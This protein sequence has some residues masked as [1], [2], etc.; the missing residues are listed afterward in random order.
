MTTIASACCPTV[1]GDEFLQPL[2]HPVAVLRLDVQVVHVDDVPGLQLGGQLA[3]RR[4]GSRARRSCRPREQLAAG[5]GVEVRDR[6][7][8]AV[9]E[10]LEVVLASGR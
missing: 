5:D 8:N 10:D 6:L 9:L 7:R 1:C 3:L 2:E 4:G